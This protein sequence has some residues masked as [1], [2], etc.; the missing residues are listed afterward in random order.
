MI[1]WDEKLKTGSD[2]I[3]KQ[4]QGL[5]DQINQL[6]LMLTE[7]NP[8]KEECEFL[9]HLVTFLEAYTKEHFQ[10]EED[11]MERHRCPAHAKNKL[12]H[13]E[14]MKFFEQFRES[15]H[16]QGFRPEIVR[17]LHE[18]MSMWIKGHILQ[19]DM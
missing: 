5:I 4:H 18:A 13:A 2:E 15:Y 12:A 16:H 19:V 9:I 1:V 14:F 3:D 11:C 10:F 17:T 6:E 8:T 7:T